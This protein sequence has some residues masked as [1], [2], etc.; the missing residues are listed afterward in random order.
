MRTTV[1]TVIIGCLLVTG[2]ATNRGRLAGV[3][4]M[5]GA[6]AGAA[7]GKDAKAAAIGSAIGGVT[8]AVVGESL[9]EQQARNEA[10][11]AQ[12][13]GQRLEGATTTQQIIAMSQAGLGDQVIA[14]HINT[15]GIANPPTANDLITLRQA[16]VSDGVLQAMQ[17]AGAPRVAAA[18]PQQVIVEEHVISPV[19]HV[20]VRPM[21]P[22]PPPYRHRRPGVSWG[23][24]WSN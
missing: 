21:R 1:L 13:M 23:F 5:T 18:A 3:G 10:I 17:T 2:C 6:M 14:T 9:D 15:Y 24:S 20:P 7:L 22:C 19:V 12:Q 16:G 11:I 4:A 8:G